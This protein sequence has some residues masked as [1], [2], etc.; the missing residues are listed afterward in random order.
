MDTEKKLS[1][2]RIRKEGGGRKRTAATDVTLK[3][4]L[5]ALIEPETRGD[6]ESP[7]AVDL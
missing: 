5:E 2:G 3:T 4:D 1:P 7:F 6:P